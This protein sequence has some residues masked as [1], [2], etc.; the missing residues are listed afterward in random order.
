MKS[1]I[2]SGLSEQQTTEMKVAFKGAIILRERLQTLLERKLEV[3]R[4]FVRSNDRYKDAAW[5]YLQ[6]DALGYESAIFEVI[7]LL[8]D[9]SVEKEEK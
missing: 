7:S 6:A 2:V 9:D 4:K 5:P 1:S 3:K 8:S